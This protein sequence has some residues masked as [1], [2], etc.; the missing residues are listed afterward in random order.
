MNFV[1]II[2]I[3]ASIK[4]SELKNQ[5]FLILPKIKTVNNVEKTMIIIDHSKKDIALD[6]YLQIYLLENF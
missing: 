3:I 6:L 4:S 5:N 2:Y 1:T